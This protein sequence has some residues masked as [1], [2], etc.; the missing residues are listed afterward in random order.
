MALANTIPTE[1]QPAQ[2][3]EGAEAA[4]PQ[5]KAARPNAAAPTAMAAGEETEAGEEASPQEQDVFTRIELGAMSMLYDDKTHA[6]FVKM[7]K[8]GEGQPAKVLAT[9]AMTVFSE[10]D[11]QSGGKI[12]EEM[13]IP[14]LVE[15][16][17]GA[18]VDLAEKTKAFPVDENVAGKA[19]QE[20]LV[21]AAQQYD[22]D[23][24]EL[25]EAIGA[26][27]AEQ[28]QQMVAQQQQFAEA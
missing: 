5:A 27:P 1:E 6:G 15:G 4:E 9:T 26:M 20:L 7:L 11:K 19:V 23:A 22:I 16:V 2:P 12:P 3:V 18:V 10:I 14:A 21:M 17:L 24:A 25:Q 28:Q 8:A 13:I